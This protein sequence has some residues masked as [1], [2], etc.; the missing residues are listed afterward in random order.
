[1][2]RRL[3]TD[4]S[5]Y[6]MVEMIVAAMMMLVIIGAVVMLL[7]S[8]MRAQPEVTD[9]AHQIG[10]A[11]IALERLTVDLRQGSA[12]DLES[13]SAIRVETICDADGDSAPC[14]VAYVCAAEGGGQTFGCTRTV[15]GEPARSFVT[16]LA[17]PDVF[18]VVPSS[19]GADCG[20]ESG[21]AEPAYVGV[22]LEFPA[23]ERDDRTILEG[24]AAL[25]NFDADA[26]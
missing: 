11:R 16:G 21:A 6:T 25:H 9:R 12:A 23:S 26:G 18:C 10:E 2:I 19:A 13:P 1:M 24:G 4:Q 22:R 7:T 15:V 14:E 3:R 8:V 20:D 17:S 5:G